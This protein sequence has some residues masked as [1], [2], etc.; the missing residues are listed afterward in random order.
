MVR[1][2]R[3]NSNH[4]SSINGGNQDD[5]DFVEGF[6]DSEQIIINL[7][8]LITFGDHKELQNLL[9]TVEIDASE[10]YDERGYNLIHICS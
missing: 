3:A 2:S 6:E 4:D 1:E 7:I 9:N 5:D 10:V 8:D